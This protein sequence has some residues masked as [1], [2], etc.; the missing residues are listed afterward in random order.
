MTRR[1]A[2]SQHMLNATAH[3]DIDWIENIT[4]REILINDALP[5]EIGSLR[6]IPREHRVASRGFPLMA[7][8]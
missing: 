2:T 5:L 1:V 3:R 4:M 8:G 7:D 6:R